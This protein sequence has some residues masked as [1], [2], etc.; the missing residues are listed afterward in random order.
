[1]VQLVKHLPPNCEVLSLNTQNSHKKKLDTT[2]HTYN[3]SIAIDESWRQ[4]TCQIANLA[5][6][7]KFWANG[8]LCL[9][10]E[11]ESA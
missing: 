7:G 4:E 10:Q 8:R 11:M 2:A 3:L 5:R 9:K 1:M 6:V